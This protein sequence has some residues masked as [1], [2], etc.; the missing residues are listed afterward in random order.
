[1]FVTLVLWMFARINQKI[2]VVN[3]AMAIRAMLPSQ[4]DV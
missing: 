1:M 2:L 4:M 3:A